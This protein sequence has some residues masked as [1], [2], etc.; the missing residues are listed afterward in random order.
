M[1]LSFPTQ[2]SISRCKYPVAVSIV[3]DKPSVIHVN[4]AVGTV[5]A[6]AKPYIAATSDR[7]TSGVVNRISQAVCYLFSPDVVQQ[8]KKTATGSSSDNTDDS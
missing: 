2:Y 1:L 7:F 3:I 8:S 4:S 5:L 6:T